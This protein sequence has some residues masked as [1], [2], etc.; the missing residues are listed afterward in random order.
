MKKAAD[1]LAQHVKGIPRSGIRD[2]FEIVQK[3]G[4]VISL[5]IGE[6]D[7]SAPW[8]V[9]EAAIYSLEHGRTGYTSNS[10][11]LK[12]RN[13]ISAYIERIFGQRYIP[14]SEILVTVGVSEAI[15]LALRA[16][17]NP[18]ETVLYHEPCYV[19]YAPSITLAHGRGRAIRT[20]AED[21][22]RLDA[23]AVAEAADGAKVLLLNFP[24][25]PTGAVLRGRELDALAK[26]CVEKNL[27]VISDEIYAELSYEGAH[28]S[29]VTRPGMRERTLLLHGL[30]KAFAMTG[31]RIGYA[32]AP[33]PLIE[34]MMKIHQ[35]AILCASTL[36]QEAAVEALRGAEVTTQEARES[37]RIRRDYLRRRLEEAGLKP[38][39][40]AGAFYLFVDVRGTGLT[41][42]DFALQLLEEEKV[43]VVPGEA[44]GPGGEG[45][46]RCSYST[47]FDRIEVAAE[48]IARFVK[49]LRQSQPQLAAAR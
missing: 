40:P 47:A 26:V 25:N 29:I 42:R 35:Y 37:Y 33:A 15:D 3:R 24:T 17:L 6:P 14:E 16:V 28:E 36:G 32:C 13:E 22:F 44:F 34:A 12:L 7:V 30:S 48:R 18:G 43:A 27:L 20:K 9:R 31:F 8:A 21:G 46:V 41:S 4:D 45:F 39:N 1:F 49:K 5:G 19:S 10:G 11:T 2:F 23:K 38:T